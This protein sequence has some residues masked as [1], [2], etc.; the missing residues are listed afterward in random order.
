MKG[1]QYDGITRENLEELYVND[2]LA[3]LDSV[4]RILGCNRE[5]VRRWMLRYGLPIRKRNT[6]Q[7]AKKAENKIL[8]D[9]EWLMS[10]MKTKT[11]KQIAD[12]YH[13]DDQVVLYWTHKYGL[14]NADKSIAIK[15][16]LQ[17]KY[18]GGRRGK[19]HPG[20]KGGRR[21]RNGYV[22]VYAPDHP[23]A[24]DGAIQEH[25]LL[26][27]QHLGRYLEPDEVVHHLNGIKDDNRIE[28][29]QVIKRGRHVHN[30]FEASH[31]V[32]AMRERIAELEQE[33]ARLRKIVGE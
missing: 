27:E 24:H 22:F 11:A 6:I 16:A 28:N 25:R 29:L 23:K 33:V 30:H 10:Q 14:I 21:I 4:G 32:L 1:P 2:P 3:T 26:M 13:L 5:T 12:E 15:D 9:R 17:K 8:E 20:W 31:E 19:N 18:P 7:G